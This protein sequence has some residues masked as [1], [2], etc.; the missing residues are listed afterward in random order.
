MIEILIHTSQFVV[1]LFIGYFCKEIGLLTQDDGKVLSTIILNLT[2]PAV[3]IAGLNGA[4]LTRTIFVMILFGLA[5]NLF[6]VLIGQW[7]Y[8]K[9]NST[10]KAFMMLTQG[11]Y[12][13]GNFVIPFVQ[14]FLPQAVPLLVGFD[15]G[16]AL[17]MF[18]GRPLMVDLATQQEGHSLSGRQVARKLLTSPAFVVYLF[19]LPLMGLGWELPQAVMNSVNMFAS[20]NAFLAMFMLGLFLN[21]NFP[22]ESI[23]TIRRILIAKYAVGF[24]FAGIV[25][26]ILPLSMTVKLTLMILAIS[27]VATASTI[28]MID[29]KVTPAAS[30]F[31]SSLSILIS[32]VFI[33]VILILFV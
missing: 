8:R 17:M 1:T 32:L 24:I 4:A 11:G 23:A 21:F 28:H 3:L 22:K 25:Y 20:A 13:I 16:N 14:G 12:N 7:L 27:P 5:A 29:Y 10:N 9:E 6:A 31:L 30:S 26:F 33:T 19:M 2:L 18:G 15:I